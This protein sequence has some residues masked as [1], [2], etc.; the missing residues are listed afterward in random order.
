MNHRP[1]TLRSLLPKTAVLASVAMTTLSGPVSLAA[2]RTPDPCVADGVCVPNRPT[3]GVYTTNW[4][5]WP[6]ERVH[7]T[8]TEAATTEEP[9]AAENLGDVQLPPPGKEDITTPEQPPGQIAPPP[10]APPLPLPGEMNVPGAAPAVDP[11]DAP[12]ANPLDEPLDAI[13]GL[14]PFGAAPPRVRLPA[15]VAQSLQEPTGASVMIVADEQAD[16]FAG[17][18]AEWPAAAMEVVVPP[19]PEMPAMTAPNL[20]DDDAPPS[21]PAS[22]RR[23]A[24]Q[25]ALPSAAAVRQRSVSANGSQ[26]QRPAAGL[27]PVRRDS[28]VAPTAVQA[29]P[30]GIQL[31]NPA[32]ALT[33]R[34]MEEGP[35][36]AIYLEATDLDGAAPAAA[37]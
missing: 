4:R 9:G 11:L 19:A 18:S 5:P 34:G 23:A 14:D 16:P 28:A 25:Q 27:A 3:W 1:T 32:A 24:W 17:S 26:A 36:H 30:S 15:S 12:P 20:Q 22:L 7:P 13:P 2:P 8:P 35:Q 10:A 29:A 21:L 37:R 31:I 6:G 33:V